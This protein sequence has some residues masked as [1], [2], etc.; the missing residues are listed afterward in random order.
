MADDG[1]HTTAEPIENPL[2]LIP[3]GLKE[4]ALDSP[5][6]RATAVHFADQIEVIE[7]W[8]DGYIKAASKL[9][10][11]VSSL[12][13]TVNSFL[14][15]SAPPAQVSEA[16]V[17]HDYT[18]LA[19]RRYGEGA[20]EFWN[21]TFRGVKKYESTVVEPIRTFLNN[22]LRVFK[23][24]RRTLDLSQKSFD[25]VI[26]R[27]LSQT[28]SKE[29]SSLREDAFQLHEAR[30]AYLKAS[31]DFCITAPQ[32]RANLDQLIVRVFAEQWKEM[33]SSR[34][35]SA[36]TFAKLNGEM[37][38]VRGW[39][40]EMENS[41]RAF[42]RE[43]MAAR[44]QIEES[45]SNMTKPSRE[46]GDY[47]LSTVP[48][49]GSGASTATKTASSA[50]KTAGH[51]TGEKQ[52]W[53]F[54]KNI[55][56]K[57]A[58]TLWSRRWFFVKNGIFGWLVQGSRSGG[59]EESEKIGV[60]LCGIRPASQEERRFCFEV[61]TKDTS[62]ILQA[63]TQTE[64]SEW[65]SAFEFA[66]RKALEDPASTEISPL[67]PGVDPAFAISPPIAPEFAA[68]MGDAEQRTED[69]ATGLSV[70]EREGSGLG[71]AQRG[72]VDINASRRVMS[73]EREPGEGGRDH[74]ARIIQKLD[75]HK[76]GSATPQLSQAP[77]P[78]AGGIASLI[79]ASHTVMPIG[80]G[81]PKS[82][83][84][85]GTTGGS[86]HRRNFTNPY[87][88]LAPNT[89]AS[90]PAPT[91]LSHTAVVVSGERGVS[92]GSRA[93]GSGMPS[94]I[95]AN[96]WG[97]SHW[98]YVN[99][100]GDDL[101][102]QPH[103]RSVSQPPSPGHVRPT[104]V[105]D[106]GVMDG[107]GE[108][109]RELPP[110]P[111]PGVAHRKTMSSIA[112][113]TDLNLPTQVARIDTE[114][115]EEY[116]NYYP[117]PLKA[118]H[119][120]FRILFPSVPR[121]E[122]IVLV[123]RATWNPNEQQEF[124]GRVYV[125][126]KDV[127]LYSHHLGLVLIT[128]VSLSSISDVT[129]APG[130][131]CDF[132]YLH[133]KEGHRQHDRRRITIRVFLDPLR[134]LQ[135]RL[136]FLVQNANSDEPVSLEEV[137]KTLIKMEIEK[138]ER[139][140]SIESW[141]DVGFDADET[142]AGDES[143]PQRRRERNIKA[144]LRIDGN[145]YG[146]IAKTGREI[147]KFQL[148]RQPVMYAPQGMQASITR[149][150]NVSA[151]AL[152]HVVFGDKSAVFQLLY[153]NRWG[154]QIIQSPW[155]KSENGHWARRFTSQYNAASMVD[156]QTIDI[157]NDHLCYVVTNQ[158]HPGGLPYANRFHCV[159]KLVVTHVSKS[160]CKLAIFQQINWHKGPAMPY[161][162]HLIEKEAFN[163]LEA[164]ALDL[165]NV[166]TD[167]VAKLGN[168][169]K[170]NKAIEVFGNIG[171]QTNVPQLDSGA[172]SNLGG[173]PTTVGKQT[174]PT[175][176]FNLVAANIMVEVLRSL[177]MAFDVLIALGKGAIGVCT[178]HSLLLALLVFSAL[179]NSWY[180][181]R[182][183]MIWWH[184]RSATKYMTRL[185]VKPEPTIG[186]AVYLS[187][188]EE[189]VVPIAVNETATSFSPPDGGE[190]KTCRTTFGEHLSSSTSLL[191][192]GTRL[193]RSRDAMARYRHD[194]LVAIRVVN[195]IERD[196]VLAEWQDWVRAEEAKCARV[197]EML[198]DRRHSG[199]KNRG[200]TTVEVEE[201]DAEL[202][203]GFARY[204]A[205]C[206]S[207]SAAFANR[208]LLT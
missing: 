195:R 163:N 202:G 74:A 171:Q 81:T 189:L 176:L 185:G 26:A 34:D 182:D 145:L 51:E 67:S 47:E 6:F 161:I 12:E 68:R 88:T 184:K 170:T 19:M 98:G 70:P 85:D 206:R 28:K 76:R 134:L 39:S 151:K 124:P 126:E 158:K 125:T 174:R 131:D 84:G 156:Q 78:S 186:R 200:T 58:R 203:D 13:A 65:I 194:L 207:E 138:P 120:Q 80:P 177:S 79:S 92:L 77:P 130:R 45:A 40:R 116:P 180:G 82:A 59:V 73:L 155:V 104:S 94:G 193:H 63:E 75:L 62:I 1:A 144:N 44:R 118:Q 18:L 133:M 31:M 96:L 123:F 165:T 191:G 22:E 72:S 95:M 183:G 37:E 167:Q 11:E 141:E 14:T 99:R 113:A 136:N 175:N 142:V 3:V 21:Q 135:R 148:P 29:A 32:L 93:D 150:F 20:R 205:S 157:F 52:G 2:N 162:R 15:Q 50:R 35:A 128:G 8:L 129:A 106:V 61:K 146:E 30:K 87:S 160:R 9:A 43:L 48:Y 168:H 60:L 112:A 192:S 121:G 89:L 188:I 111:E 119:A 4:A 117:L 86:A 69:A 201:L 178:A 49:L 196:V 149:E 179:Y 90:P 10:A 173:P 42:K 159:T 16:V 7:R 199:K 172:V 46:L 66:K 33:R 25:T 5:T 83:G 103:Q 166:A 197:E 204:C 108:M 153:S 71:V 187:D 38:R 55:I 147:Q 57:P 154:V 27:Y 190:A 122:K 164:D 56:G 64:I 137:I 152:F 140:S 208:T 109:P 53:L 198:L 132:L 139:S 23:D 169:S 105:D 100:L 127:Y 143:S 181:Y 110:S 102:K 107:T 41:E 36:S 115:V 24:A 97:S 114:S 17:D 91:N 54:M 101:P